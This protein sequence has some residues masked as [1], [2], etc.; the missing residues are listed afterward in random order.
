MTKSAFRNFTFGVEDSLAST[1][2]LLSGIA[3][4]AV[5]SQ[6]IIITGIILIFT[7]A[8]SM[9]IG[10]FLSETTDRESTR[11]RDGVIMF[12]SYSLAGIIPLFPYAVLPRPISLYLSIALTLLALFVLGTITRQT[13]R[14]VTLGGLVALCSV[15]LGNLLKAFS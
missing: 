7:E 1:V 13:W 12:F 2:G 14:V 4:A 10:S 11:R 3:S 6:T 15:V 8:L 5:N 9:G